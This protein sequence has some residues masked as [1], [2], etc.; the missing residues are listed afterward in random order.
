VPT[1]KYNFYLTQLT[2]SLL[3]KSKENN[4]VSACLVS[5]TIIN[6]AQART[7]LVRL[8]SNFVR[9]I[10]ILNSNLKE[11]LQLKFSTVEGRVLS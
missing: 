3:G 7:Y 8:L 11:G 6:E 4:L 5:F 2:I 9:M 10:E 1:Y